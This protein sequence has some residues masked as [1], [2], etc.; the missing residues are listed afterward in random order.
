MAD[1]LAQH[2]SGQRKPPPFVRSAVLGKAPGT[3]VMVR[4]DD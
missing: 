2:S 1:W 3:Y 4:Y